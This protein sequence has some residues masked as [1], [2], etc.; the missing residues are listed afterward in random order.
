MELG[1]YLY[2]VVTL[3]EYFYSKVDEKSW[4]DANNSHD[5]TQ[6]AKIRQ[7]FSVSHRLVYTKTTHFRK[8]HAME[9]LD[10]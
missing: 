3:L 8:V 10:R 7:L 5:Y 4:N 2:Y 6:R 1:A 9:V